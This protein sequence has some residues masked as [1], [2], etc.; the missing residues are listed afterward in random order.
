[1]RDWKTGIITR[2]GW[3]GIIVMLALTGCGTLNLAAEGVVDGVIA[4]AEKVTDKAMT[5]I[6]EAVSLL[7]R[8]ADRARKARCR[9]PFSALVRYAARGDKETAVLRRDCALTVDKA[10]ARAVPVVRTP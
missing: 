7:E 3:G 1:M 10:R 9:L 5:G 4:G 8:K 6:D 2:K